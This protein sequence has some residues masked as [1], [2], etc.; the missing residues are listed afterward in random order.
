MRQWVVKPDHIANDL[1][2]ASQ[3][4]QHANSRHTR[5]RRGGA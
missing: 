5:N 1:K 4:I 3:I 2:A